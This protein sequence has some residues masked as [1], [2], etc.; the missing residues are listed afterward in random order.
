MVVVRDRMGRG[1]TTLRQIAIPLSYRRFRL[2]GQVQSTNCQSA[3]PPP[4]CWH[5]RSAEKRRAMRRVPDPLAADLDSIDI[6]RHRLQLTPGYSS[7]AISSA[8]RRYSP[9]AR[10]STGLSSSSA[11][12]GR[13][14][15][16]GM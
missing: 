1:Q 16:T 11:S 3:L 5:R 8:T 2:V 12:I 9:R 4:I 10:T 14:S 7:W 13:L 15:Q 6:E